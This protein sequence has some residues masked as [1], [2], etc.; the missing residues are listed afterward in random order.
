MKYRFACM[1]LVGLALALLAAGCQQPKS[2]Q[3]SVLS[4]EDTAA[5]GK[6][7]DSTI[8]TFIAKDIDKFMANFSPNVVN[9]EYERCYRGLDELRD[10]HAKPEMAD[11]TMTIYKS[12]DRHIH[13]RSEFAYVSEREIVD[14]K[15]KDGKPHSSD[16]CWAS[17]VLEKASDGKWKIVQMHFSGPS[18]L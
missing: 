10:K 5:I 9:M 17:Y 1:M 16:S 6:T 7:I 2:E 15:D 18:T 11:L 8:E 3:T 12:S 14:F 4:A 13:G